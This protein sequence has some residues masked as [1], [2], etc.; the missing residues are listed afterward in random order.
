MTATA[1][2]VQVIG[3]GAVHQCFGLTYASYLVIP[4]SV[5]QSLPVELQQRFV[6]CLEE[7]GAL[8]GSVPS[9][10]EYEVQLRGANGRYMT[11]PLMDYERGR[12]RVPL[13]GA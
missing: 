12:R 1:D 13:K 5:L 3:D 11:D 9:E 7:M 4:R 8:V 10:G 2:E 6:G